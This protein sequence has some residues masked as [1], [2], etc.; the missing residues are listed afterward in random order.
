MTHWVVSK[1]HTYLPPVALSK[2]ALLKTEIFHPQISP[3]IKSA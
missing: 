3:L 1:D 2:S